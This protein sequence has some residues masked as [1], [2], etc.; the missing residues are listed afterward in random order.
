[1]IGSSNLSAVLGAAPDATADI[2]TLSSFIRA[3]CGTGLA[4]LLIAPGT[5]IPVD[6]RTS[7]QKSKDDTAAQAQ[8]KIDGRGD[9]R[10]ARSLA[11]SHLATTDAS[12]VI[13][14]VKRYRDTFGA[15]AAVNFAAEVGRSGLVVVDADT[16]DQVSAFL[17][18]A[19][20]HTDDGKPMDLPPTVSTPG[21]VDDDGTWAHSDGGHF[22]FTLDPGEEL[23]GTGA[24]TAPGGYVAMYRNRY[25]LIPPSVRPEGRYRLTGREYPAPDWLREE[26]TATGRAREHTP[27][28][29]D[30]PFDNAGSDD[31]A[32]AV[33][34]WAET[35][36]WS[37]ILAPMG[38]TLTARPDRCGCDIWTAP[39]DHSS[40]KSA[41]THDTGCDLG[42]YTVDNAPMH[43]WTDHP[44]DEFEAW[45]KETGSATLSKLQALSVAEYGSDVGTAAAELGLIKSVDDLAVDM[46]VSKANM[47][48]ALSATPTAPEDVAVP[49]TPGEDSDASA[50]DT[51]TE[52][53][54]TDNVLRTETNGVPRIAPFDHWRTTAAPEW[55]IEGILE[56]GATAML[57]GP[58][59]AGKSAVA[60]DMACALVSG[61]HWQGRKTIRQKVLY[62]PGEGLHGAVQRVLAWEQAHGKNVGED[63]LLG[64]SIIQLGASSK[65]WEVLGAYIIRHRVGLIIFD[66]FARMA[67][68]VEENSA[69]DV[70][71]AVTRFDQLRRWTKAGVMIVHHTSKSSTSA[72]GS[73][74]LWGAVESQVLVTP[75]TWDSSA[76]E[77]KPIDVHIQKQKNGPETDE[78]IPVLMKQMHDSVVITGPSG[79]VGDPL[80]GVAEAPMV[81]PE[82]MV[83]TAVRV[84]EYLDRFPTQGLTRTDLFKYLRP[85]EHTLTRR[86]PDLHWRRSV[87]EAVDLAL[88]Y[89]LIQTLSGT[90]SGSRFIPGPASA[91]DARQ[92]AA[93]EAMSD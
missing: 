13:K 74:A 6:M 8:A 1:M 38:W 88:R 15:D 27:H 34:Q 71:K 52:L 90:A 29:P 93:K 2:P 26:I 37:D 47:S 20:V 49:P 22:Y 53:V 14:Y 73:S 83:E 7:Q 41:T 5:K 10:K 46:G 59:G 62:L 66:T 48:D 89:T 67:L 56:H 55:S 33:D 4:L 18:D 24:W 16:A 12:T 77:G 32:A 25:I 31:L 43:I 61:Q 70:G 79:D 64:D 21:S 87:T 17:T 75:G 28:D 80:A 86:D 51:D 3:A 84:R 63:L 58:P 72:R 44:G 76:V 19:G 36:T 78:P 30:S 68:D 40:P 81:I 85:D 60:L 45:I 9:W 54:D 65:A 82:P 11:G 23:P 92:R 35:I 50:G 39:G 91:E 69:T 42:R 57:I